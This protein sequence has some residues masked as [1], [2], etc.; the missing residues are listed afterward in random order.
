MS[1]EKRS[2]GIFSRRHN[3]LFSSSQSSTADNRPR[4]LYDSAKPRPPKDHHGGKDKVGEKLNKLLQFRKRS[5]S[6]KND[7]CNISTYEKSY[8]PVPPNVTWTN[9]V[10]QSNVSKYQPHPPT[11]HP[12]NVMPNPKKK[13]H[14]PKP[15]THVSPYIEA[16]T[17]PLSKHSTADGAMQIDHG[18]GIVATSTYSS[19]SNESVALTNSASTGRI[20]SEVFYNINAS[21]NSSDLTTTKVATPLPRAA[22]DGSVTPAAQYLTQKSDQSLNSLSTISSYNSS[23]DYKDVTPVETS[24]KIIEAELSC[25]VNGSANTSPVA[26]EQADTLLPSSTSDTPAICPVL[27]DKPPQDQASNTT[28][29]DSSLNRSSKSEDLNSNDLVATTDGLHAGDLTTNGALASLKKQKLVLEELLKETTATE[30]YTTPLSGYVQHEP[31][32]VPAKLSQSRDLNPSDY[33]RYAESAISQKPGASL[34]GTELIVS[35]IVEDLVTAVETKLSKEAKRSNLSQR[36]IIAGENSKHRFNP[37]T[38]KS[39]NSDVTDGINNRQR[40]ELGVADVDTSKRPKSH[41]HRMSM[42]NASSGYSSP[43]SGDEAP[44]SPE[45]PISPLTIPS[46]TSSY[47]SASLSASSSRVSNLSRELPLSKSPAIDENTTEDNTSATMKSF[48]RPLA[49]LTTH[50]V[51][52]ASGRSVSSLSAPSAAAEVAENGIKSTEDASEK[53]SNAKNDIK[54]DNL[55]ET[56]SLSDIPVKFRSKPV[57]KMRSKSEYIP[58]RSDHPEFVERAR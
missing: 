5:K 50:T 49:T 24:S 11:T 42:D 14:A 40:K 58:Y 18:E 51:T 8:E 17:S 33:Y 41:K 48:E 6:V 46:P 45:T 54:K 44:L 28:I 36:P 55:L 12:T 22:G 32:K 25:I 20:D 35:L 10:A 9:V 21:S 1:T 47:Y 37:P 15:P 26:T 13:R 29:I 56:D 4:S 53:Q 31:S 34:Q 52:S 27:L 3:K 2:P 38:C 30:S 43:G 16:P 19:N 39:Q 57:V 23:S 7:D